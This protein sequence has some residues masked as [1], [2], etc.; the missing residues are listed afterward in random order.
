MA[1]RKRTRRVS[2]V[3]AAPAKRGRKPK[4]DVD[5]AMGR[6]Q[7]ACCIVSTVTKALIHIQETHGSVPPEEADDEL[8]TLEYGVKQFRSALDEL[9][10]A[11]RQLS[12]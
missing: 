4:I 12:P 7:E 10:V 11:Y 1:K 6:L 5:E 3:K 9:D 2:A 8:T